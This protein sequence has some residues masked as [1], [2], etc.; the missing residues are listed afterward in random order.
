MNG[1]QAA[2]WVMARVPPPPTT[3]SHAVP[4]N[5]A[6]SEGRSARILIVQQGPSLA[7]IDLKLAGYAVDVVEHDRD[8]VIRL[9]DNPPDL[10]ILDAHTVHTP[11]GDFC[12]R[13]RAFADQS[14]VLILT[15]VG[16]ETEGVRSMTAGAD[17]FLV[18]PVS[19]ERLLPRIHALLRRPR[20]DRTDPLLC[21]AD[22][23]LDLDCHRASRAGRPLHLGPTEFRLLTLLMGCPGQVLSREH[24]LAE[25]W[26]PKARVGL[27]TV[28]IWISR[29][30]K[31]LNR[32]RRRDALRTVWGVG[33]ALKTGGVS[34]K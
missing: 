31:V 25:V 29:L 19:V 22:L 28:D 26:G 1:Q 8:A 4:S 32:G 18:N 12:T 17:D 9:R 7:L 33:Y 6:V 30:R 13:V 20:P 10:L 11:D 15:L 21:V 5:A 23:K 3:S 34:Q 16:D 27:R 14:P 24:L 2:G